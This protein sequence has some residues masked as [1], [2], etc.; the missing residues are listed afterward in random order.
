[1]WTH[2]TEKM[3]FVWLEEMQRIT[4]KGAP[5]LIS[6]AGYASLEAHRKRDANTKISADDLRR[7]RFIFH[8]HH[9]HN[10]N[11]DKWPGV[12]GKYGLARH[13]PDYIRDKWSK[14][15]RVVDIPTCNNSYAGS[16]YIGKGLRKKGA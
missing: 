13:D 2:L 6:T 1:V 5:L 7:K 14:Y 3:Q 4:K 15:F 12:S 11:P 16:G 8:E 10:T 9:A